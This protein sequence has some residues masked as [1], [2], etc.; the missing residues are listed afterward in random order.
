MDAAGRARGSFEVFA[1]GFAGAKRDPEGAAHRPTGIA[2]GPDGALYVS[3]D[4]GGRIY[5]IVRR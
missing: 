3:D 2:M 4:Q 1:D 5:R